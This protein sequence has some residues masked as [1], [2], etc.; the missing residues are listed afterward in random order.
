MNQIAI[1]SDSVWPNKISGTFQP[2]CIV[3]YFFNLRCQLEN[4]IK[5]HLFIQSMRLFLPDS[6]QHKNEGWSK[7]YAIIGSSSVAVGWGTKSKINY[8]AK[9][10]VF[11]MANLQIISGWKFGWTIWYHNYFLGIKIFTLFT[12]P[13][14]FKG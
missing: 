4:W 7:K 14:V 10:C 12:I 11:A 5:Y 3:L 8:R 9:K 2:I 1:Q 6:T 13:V